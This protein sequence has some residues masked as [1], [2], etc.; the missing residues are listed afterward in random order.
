MKII[1]VQST[2][3]MSLSCGALMRSRSTFGLVMHNCIKFCLKAAFGHEQVTLYLSSSN[4]W[5]HLIV[6]INYSL[7][8]PYIVCE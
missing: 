3:V 5:T 4:E 2:K 1:K 7:T 6:S 8:T